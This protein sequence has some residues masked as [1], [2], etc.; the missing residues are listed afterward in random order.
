MTFWKDF[1]EK[2]WN[3]LEKFEKK[4]VWRTPWR[5]SRR[6]S[7]K[8]HVGFGEGICG[9]IYEF[10]S[11]ILEW[12][13]AIPGKVNGKTLE[14]SQNHSKFLI[15]WS[16]RWRIFQRNPWR[17]FQENFRKHFQKKNNVIISEEVHG[18][19]REILKQSPE[20]F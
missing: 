13:K 14:N 6:I 19:L 12:S 20:K 18:I 16:N 11:G 15:F 3:I 8:N 2:P 4:N 10:L 5:N 7:K 1:P 9:A 17:S